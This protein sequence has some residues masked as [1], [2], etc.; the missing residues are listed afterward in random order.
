MQS[1]KDRVAS[2]Q[3]AQREKQAASQERETLKKEIKK[4]LQSDT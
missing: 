4:E 2:Y 1:Q 3:S